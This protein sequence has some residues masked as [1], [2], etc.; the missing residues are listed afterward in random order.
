MMT[1]GDGNI[2]D[3]KKKRGK[4]NKEKTINRTLR[5]PIGGLNWLETISTFLLFGGLY[6]D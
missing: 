4:G 3:G 6:L 1:G 5:S 2:G